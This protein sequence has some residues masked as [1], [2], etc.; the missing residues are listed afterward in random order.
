MSLC[1][2]C[3]RACGI[4]RSEHTPPEKAGFCGMGTAP[5]LARAALH[6]DEEPC[7]SGSR[8][9]GAIFFSGCTLRCAFCQNEP[10]SHGRF[11]AEV[12]TGGLRRIMERLVNE[13]EAHN[14]NLVTATH[15]ADAVID[16][17][18]TPI[19]V[20]VVWNSSGFETVDTLRRLEG[21]VQ[22]Y[23][24]DF[25]FMDPALASRLAK[26]SSYPAVAKKA[27]LEMARQVG[28]N[29]FDDEGVMTRGLM[30][31]HLILPGHVDDSK[32][33][34]TWI[35]DNL[36]ANTWVSL[37]AQYTPCGRAAG[38]PDLGRRLTQEE[39]DE[40]VDHLFG[41]GLDNGYVQELSSATEEYIPRFDL[42]GVTDE[43]NK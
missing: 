9:S 37:M 7:I 38:L 24:P 18:K 36:P 43:K 22:V 11:G 19:G 30:I 6:F 14:I 1:T 28:E 42:T 29:T 3:P 23:L 20:P 10:I 2:L 8:G 21:T 27:I 13:D 33:V 35:H 26:A 40:V 17:L 16:A 34:L 31:R 41:L 15:F 32:A 25:K 12:T 4:E 39:Y 5:V